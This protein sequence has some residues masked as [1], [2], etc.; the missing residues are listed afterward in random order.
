MTCFLRQF[1]SEPCSGGVHRHHLIKAQVIKRTCKQAGGSN[2]SRGTVRAANDPRITVKVCS[3]HHFALH[4]GQ[5]VVPRDALPEGVELFAKEH[6]L[7]WY[8][9][10]HFGVLEPA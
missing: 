1:S 9:D 3:S 7:G 10:K 2:R 4:A 6:G 8:L 5:I